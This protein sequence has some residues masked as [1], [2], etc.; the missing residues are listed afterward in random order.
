M[1]TASHNT[2]PQPQ[3]QPPE[4]RQPVHRAAAVQVSEC[5][6]HHRGRRDGAGLHS[7]RIGDVASVSSFSGRGGGDLNEPT[8]RTSMIQVER[9]QCFLPLLPLWSDLSEEEEKEEEEGSE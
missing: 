5:R 2:Q 9:E 7:H 6:V 8:H 3:P 1:T 4:V